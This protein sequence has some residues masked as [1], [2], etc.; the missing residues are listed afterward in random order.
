MEDSGLIL[1]DQGKGN[2]LPMETCRD[3]I[4]VIFSAKPR[5]IHVIITAIK[6]KNFHHVKSLSTRYY[7]QNVKVAMLLF[8]F[9]RCIKTNNTKQTNKQTNPLSVC[10]SFLVHI[11]KGQNHAGPDTFVTLFVHDPKPGWFFQ[12]CQIGI[13]RFFFLVV[14]FFFFCLFVF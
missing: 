4:P 11:K 2:S 12:V 5:N 13:G 8:S 10:F 6:L 3:Q 1:K 7:K 14:F 9:E